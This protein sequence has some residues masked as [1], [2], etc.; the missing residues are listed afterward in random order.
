MSLPK[1]L[2]MLHT[3]S[4]YFCTAEKFEDK[5]EWTIPSSWSK[6]H[7]EQLKKIEADYPRELEALVAE[8]E[9]R[10]S[11]SPWGS[12]RLAAEQATTEEERTRLADVMKQ[13]MGR[14]YFRTY[15]PPLEQRY[16]NLKSNTNNTIAAI[17]RLLN[18]M[19]TERAKGFINCWFENA[20]ESIGMWDIYSNREGGIAIQSTVGRLFGCLE[21][22][23][24]DVH[25]G[26]ISYID[27]ETCIVDK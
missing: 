18:S 13:Q 14:G 2:T 25:I 11:E 21:A 16:I 24:Q 9:R 1:F 19:H 6:A 5:Y 4:L 22:V 7:M 27:F 17:S 10:I 23:P 20:H 26:K 12:S 3:K 15:G 8:F